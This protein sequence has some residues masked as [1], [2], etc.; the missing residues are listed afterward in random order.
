MDSAKQN[1]PLGLRP[2]T[3][4][5]FGLLVSL[6]AATTDIYFPA[7]PSLQAFFSVDAPAVQT[8]LSIFLVGLACGQMVFGPLSDRFGRRGLLLAGVALFA[9]GSILAAMAME[10]WVL[11][12]ARFIQAIGAAAA[13]VITRAMVTDRFSGQQAARIHGLL[14]QIMAAAT[15]AAPVIGG[16]V[17]LMY[18]WQAI[19]L[20]LAAFGLACLVA[21]WFS[22]AET[23][24]PERRASGGFSQ[25]WAAWLQLFG[26]ARFVLLTLASGFT[27]A[28][29]Y[30]LMMGSA[31]VYIDEFGWSTRDYGLLYGATTVCFI[32]AAW[33]NDLVLRRYPPSRLIAWA[34]PVQ[35]LTCLGMVAAALSGVLSPLVLA[36]VL[37]FLMANVAFVHGNLVAA[38]L[39]EAR[40]TPGLGA[41]LLGVAQYG[42]SALNPLAAELAGGTALVSMAMSTAGFAVLAVLPL[43]LM[44]RSPAP[45]AA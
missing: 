39:E 44:R 32:A 7:L 43:L 11:L 2:G 36:I 4:L 8:T 15:I 35:M 38:V 31:F 33:G 34:L 40:L 16:W 28:A 14:M 17:V 25:L 3:L 13:V 6:G 30:A 10:L 26:N 42:I 41:G 45:A 1:I 12:A 20:L 37:C 19:F 24:P 27:M 29:M 18:D 5:L 22:T 23:L 9:F 21:A